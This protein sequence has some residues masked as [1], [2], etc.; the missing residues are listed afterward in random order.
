[1]QFEDLLR[2]QDQLAALIG[3]P[4]PAQSWWSSPGVYPPINVFRTGDG[5]VIKAELPGVRPED[6]EIATEGRQLKITGERRGAEDEH[7]SPHR[8]ERAQ[9]RFS[10]SV[11]LPDELDLE[12]VEAQCRNGVLTLKIAVAAAAKPRQIAV[13]VA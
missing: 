7:K 11:W 12:H 13:K 4:A 2:L 9:G 3:A 6:V 1:M 10:R 8:R 5:M